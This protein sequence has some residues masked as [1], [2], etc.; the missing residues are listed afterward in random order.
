MTDKRPSLNAVDR[1]IEYFSPHTAARRWLARDA[2]I[3][4]RAYDAAKQTRSTAN[5]RA[6][7]GSASE[8]MLGGMDRIRARARDC[9]RNNPYAKRASDVL[10]SNL[11][12]TGIVIEP[13]L[14]EEAAEWANWIDYCDAAGEHDGYGLQAL[15]ARHWKEDGEVL[16]RFRVRDP[17]D[18]YRVPLQIQ[19]LEIDHLDTSKTGPASNGNM[20]IAGVEF[21]LIGKRVAYWLFPNHPGEVYYAPKNLQSVRVDAGLVLHL[22]TKRRASQVRS[23][24]EFATALLRYRDLDDY[25]DAVRIKKKIE[26]CFAAFVTTG[27]D[28]KTLGGLG[29]HDSGK[30]RRERVA[31]GMIEYLYADESV[32]FA[33]PPSSND[34][35]YTTTELRA[36]AMG[37]GV[38]YAQ[39][40]GDNSKANFSSE[41][42]GLTE[43]RMLIEQDQW[44]TFVPH[45][46]RIRA[47]W[48]EIA[49]L[50]QVRLGNEPDKISVPKKPWLD[51]LKDVL[52][53]KEAISGV[54][55][56]TPESIR[57]RGYDPEKVRMEEAAWRKQC[58]EDGIVSDTDAAVSEL[59]TAGLDLLKSEQA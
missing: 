3:Q 20:V 39:L 50:S 6:G 17:R 12:G 1:V 5:W 14:K 9:I 56:S 16:I 24:S 53:E 26:A 54:L 8:E 59:K 21:N 52:A 44:L 13:A 46:K 42:V 22:Y 4:V 33:Q 25:Q 19:V 49:L 31:P 41:R 15:A 43:F 7:N 27:N 48:R 45:L 34:E 10:V 38:T 29:D 32:S 23:V 58:K 36:I 30:P 2:L 47:K 28:R 37:S 57:M 18:G 11:V 55:M 35:S 40:T 51:P